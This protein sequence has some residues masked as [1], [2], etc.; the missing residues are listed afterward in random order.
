MD[1]QTKRRPGFEH[2]GQLPESRSGARWLAG[3]SKDVRR[4][5]GGGK[6]AFHFSFRFLARL[7]RF[8]A[9]AARCSVPTKTQVPYQGDPNSVFRI[10][11]GALHLFTL[12]KA[13]CF[14]EEGFRDIWE[15]RHLATLA[16]VRGRDA[17]E[18][19]ECGSYRFVGHGVPGSSAMNRH[20][21]LGAKRTGLVCEVHD[22]AEWAPGV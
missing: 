11:S 9:R 6:K 22:G 17:N 5:K 10:A 12:H 14:V 20:K 4:A 3:G 19:G 13:A 1:L 8:I 15:D 21:L 18:L 7:L 16:E 2:H